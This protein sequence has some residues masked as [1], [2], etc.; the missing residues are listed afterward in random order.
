MYD[1][2]NKK[3]HMAEKLHSV[4]EYSSRKIMVLKHMLRVGQT[5]KETGTT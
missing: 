4:W 3:M 2:S 1:V 5:F